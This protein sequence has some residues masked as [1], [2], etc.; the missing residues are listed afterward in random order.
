[1]CTTRITYRRRRGFDEAARKPFVQSPGA[2]F[3]HIILH[4]I[5]LIHIYIYIYI[6]NNNNNTTTT[7]NTTTN[8]NHNHNT[9]TYIPLL[10]PDYIII[11]NI[12]VVILII[13]IFTSR[14]RAAPRPLRGL[15]EASVSDEAT[16]DCTYVRK[17]IC[18]YIYIYIYI[19]TYDD[20]DY[21]YYYYIRYM[22]Y[23]T[24]YYAGGLGF[25]IA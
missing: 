18:V 22:I 3:Y 20:D 24:R 23:I 11:N 15:R 19:H 16:Q 9:N 2:E 25:N 17:Y 6:H 4:Y 12:I 8:H 21:Y 5:T 14:R 7:T 10:L 1:M 13:N